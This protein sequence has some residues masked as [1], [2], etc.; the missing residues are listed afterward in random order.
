V[1]V[2]GKFGE[3]LVVNSAYHICIEIDRNDV[4]NLKIIGE[5]VIYIFRAEI[6]ET[7]RHVS[8]LKDGV[9]VGSSDSMFDDLI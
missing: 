8:E 1:D 3:L 7:A 5:E 9:K 6:D 2:T 4:N